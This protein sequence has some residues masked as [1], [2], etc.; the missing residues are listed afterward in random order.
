MNYARK[1]L[2]GVHVCGLYAVVEVLLRTRRL[3]EVC[4]ALGVALGAEPSTPAVAGLAPTTAHRVSRA[5]RGARLVGARW[6][7]RGTCLRQSLVAGRLLRD[8]SPALVMGVRRDETGAL[9]AHAWLVVDGCSLDV[10]SPHY[11]VLDV[12]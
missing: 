12:G 3:P 9:T 7:W 4:S 10:E 1:L 8:L 5:L 6:P 2:R 11:A